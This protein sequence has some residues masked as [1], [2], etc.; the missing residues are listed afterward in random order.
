VKVDRDFWQDRKVLVTGA[1]GYIGREMLQY[2]KEFGAKV[3]AWDVALPKTELDGVQYR[4]VNMMDSAAVQE[5]LKTESAEVLIHLAGQAGVKASHDFPRDAFNKN[6]ICTFNLLEVLK[7]NNCFKSVVAVST[8]HVYGD[9]GKKPSSESAPL[10]GLGIYA[11]TK[12]CSDILARS[13][14]QSFG[15]PLAVARIT[16]SFGGDDPHSGHIITG[17]ISLVEKGERPVIKNSGKDSKGYLHID[18]TIGG[19]FQLASHLYSHPEMAGEAF[20]ISSSQPVA[21][22]DLVKTI[23]SVLGSDLEAEVLKPDSEFETEHLDIS[24]MRDQ[25]GWTPSMTLADGLKRA[26][27]TRAGE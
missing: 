13:F 25:V 10:N 23:I 19:L 17:T 3:T 5:N 9:Q 22:S 14:A 1:N 20:N 16:N 26:I 4:E 11:A 12:S 7:E 15:I 6:V 2:L 8:N 21:V 18:D 24:R 27:E